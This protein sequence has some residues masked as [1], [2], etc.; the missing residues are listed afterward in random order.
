M[1]KKYRTVLIFLSSFFILFGD[2]LFGNNNFKFLIYFSIIIFIVGLGNKLREEESKRNQ[3]INTL[4]NITKD[5]DGLV[6]FVMN[7]FKVAR[8]LNKTEVEDFS[9]VNKE[10]YFN[11]MNDKVEIM[12][13]EYQDKYFE[14]RECVTNFKS[15]S[16]FY[17]KLFIYIDDTSKWND[18]SVNK[19][20]T[21]E[22]AIK[23]AKIRFNDEL[24]N[25]K[26]KKIVCKKIGVNIR[27]DF[28]I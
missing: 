11:L 25:V 9:N 8:Y 5:Y 1:I 10:E 26:V 24:K 14:I 21:E 12:E 18:I 22:E 19:W 28:I 3:D 23:K 6:K 4:M 7:K 17:G 2:A 13:D 16:D 15:E 20:T 27:I